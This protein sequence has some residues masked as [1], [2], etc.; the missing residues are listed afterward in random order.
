MKLIARKPLDIYGTKYARGDVVDVS[1]EAAERLIR[2]GHARIT[3]DELASHL[4]GKR[5]TTPTAK[6]DGWRVNRR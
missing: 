1:Q 4:A 2:T 6:A 3:L 5:F